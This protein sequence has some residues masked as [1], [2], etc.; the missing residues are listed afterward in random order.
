MSK[1]H[2]YES[3][4]QLEAT[5]LSPFNFLFSSE[6][7]TLLVPELELAHMISWE[8]ILCTSTWLP[9]QWHHTGGLMSQLEI[10]TPWKYVDATNRYHFSPWRACC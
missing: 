5:A 9:I 4:S 3:P 6:W 7:I 2:F 8:Q 10:F 1:D